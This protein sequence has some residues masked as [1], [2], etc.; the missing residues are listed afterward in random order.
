MGILLT[1]SKKEA[2]PFF[3]LGTFVPDPKRFF[4]LKGKNLGFYGKF[5]EP[6]LKPK[7]I[8]P[9]RSDSSNKKLIALL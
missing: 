9:T 6:R 8:D 4:Y 3:D 7:M 5:S 2:K 1:R